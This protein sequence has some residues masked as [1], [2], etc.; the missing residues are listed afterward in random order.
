MINVE[1][2]YEFEKIQESFDRHLSPDTEKLIDEVG[3]WVLSLEVELDLM[4]KRL[5][6]AI[7]HSN[8]YCDKC[9]ALT[10]YMDFKRLGAE[11]REMEPND[12]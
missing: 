5:A 2:F 1:N 9:N 6:Q 11:P 7:G 12:R 3:H 8:C 10:K 4:L